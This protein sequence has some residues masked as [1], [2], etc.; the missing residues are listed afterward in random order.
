MDSLQFQLGFNLHFYGIY[1]HLA[2]LPFAK[3]WPSWKKTLRRLFCHPIKDQSLVDLPSQHFSNTLKAEKAQVYGRDRKSMKKL[4]QKLQ[5]SWFY[6][7]LMKFLTLDR[8]TPTGASQQFFMFKS[9]PVQPT[10]NATLKVPWNPC[11]TQ[12]FRSQRDRALVL[13]RLPAG[14]RKRFQGI[15]GHRVLND[16]DRICLYWICKHRLHMEK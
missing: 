11:A 14:G 6:E 1:M 8:E 10:N 16:M 3:V 2:C 7:N 5:I 15:D 4:R 9:Y 13:Q 12:A